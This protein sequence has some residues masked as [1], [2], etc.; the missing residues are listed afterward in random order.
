MGIFSTILS[1]GLDAFTHLWDVFITPPAILNIPFEANDISSISVRATNFTYVPLRVGEYSVSYKGVSVKR[2]GAEISGD[3][4]FSLTFR[5]DANH[6]LYQALMKWKHLWA[7][8]SLE[9]Q[10]QFGGLSSADDQYY[11]IVKVGAYNATTTLDEVALPNTESGRMGLLWVFHN[12]ICTDVS[13]P[14]FAREGGSPLTFSA[15]FIYGK[16]EEPPKVS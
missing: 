11:G 12:V 5:G 13:F 15:T 4:T 8:P 10:V 6:R 14:Q 9:G 2:I 7:D 16:V 3:R 1:S